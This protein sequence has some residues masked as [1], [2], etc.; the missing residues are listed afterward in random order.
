MNLIG[1]HIKNN[2]LIIP[3]YI[4]ASLIILIVL[5]TIIYHISS[6]ILDI[7]LRF[8]KDYPFLYLTLTMTYILN[9]L[10]WVF[11]LIGILFLILKRKILSFLYVTSSLIIYLVKW[12]LAFYLVHI[13]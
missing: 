8:Y 2:P 11:L 7:N 12:A 9:L 1:H 10:S 6:D 3:I 13:F 5:Y 4:L